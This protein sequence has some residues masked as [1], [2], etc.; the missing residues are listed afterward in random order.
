MEWNGMEWNR[1]ESNVIGWILSVPL[2]RGATRENCIRLRVRATRRTPPRHTAWHIDRAAVGATF[3]FFP[4]SAKKRLRGTTANE[5]SPGVSREPR[6]A[7][8]PC[9]LATRRSRR[10]SPRAAV[11]LCWLL[12]ASSREVARAP[13]FDG[14]VHAPV[15]RHLPRAC[16]GMEWSGIEWNGM[17]TLCQFPD[18]FHVR[19]R[20]NGME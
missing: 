12:A 13:Q 15:P 5:S 4:V 17:G 10:T 18:I 19:V 2:D 16:V 11:V 3:F 9:R 20:G 6:A 8:T 7:Y 14:V 1:M